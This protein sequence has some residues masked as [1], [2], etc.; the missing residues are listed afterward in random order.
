MGRFYKGTSAIQADATLMTNRLPMAPSPVPSQWGLGFN[1][2]ILRTQTFSHRRLS[3]MAAMGEQ[4]I[5][6][7]NSF[8]HS[9][10]G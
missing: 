9:S 7:R 5:N 3:E 6:N 1:V 2:C 8:S 10:K 4:C